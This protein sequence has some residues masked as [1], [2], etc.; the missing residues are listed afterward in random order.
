MLS[1][2]KLKKSPSFGT[3]LDNENTPQELIQHWSPPH[4]Q[5]RTLAKGKE[6]EE[7]Q[8]VLGRRPRRR[9]ESAGV[10]LSWDRLPDELLLGIFSC[11][12]LKDLLGVSRICRRWR[13]L[14]FD[15]SLWTSVDLVGVNQM[16]AALTQLLPTGVLALRCP[17][18][19]IGEF[20]LPP[21]LQL[22]IQHLDLS[23]CIVSTAVLEDL[24]SHCR[25]LQDL[26][27]EGLELSDSIMQFLS[28]NE[29]LARLNICGCSGLSPEAVGGMLQACTRLQELNVSWCNFNND[30]IKAVVGNI[31]SSVTQLNISG[32]RQNLTMED[33][34]VLV[35]RS[36]HLTQLDLSDSVLLTADSFPL[37]QQ[38]IS[39]RHLGLSRCYQIHAAG[40][41]DLDKFPELR[42]LEVFGLVQESN[43]PMLN[44]ALSQV[45]INTC[46][47]SSVARPTSADCKDNTMWGTHCRLTFRH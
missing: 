34:K 12:S 17:R 46:F 4:K 22:R 32:Y 20:R 3:G 9:R 29:E 25:W 42:T 5:P 43:L 27:L 19:C 8:F 23:S 41:A 15:E 14:V 38:L 2:S 18:S 30:H 35:E 47:F 28:Q 26:S 45:L 10:S 40:L 16:D 31:P 11:L 6:N 21:S 37:L 39:L 7:T 33:L 36:P 44:K 1:Q 24:F 13:R